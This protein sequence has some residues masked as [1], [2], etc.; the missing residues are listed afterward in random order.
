[1]DVSAIGF[2]ILVKDTKIFPDGFTISRTADG[3]DPFAFSTVTVGSATTDANGYKVYA[4]TPNPT[5]F[6]INLLPTSEEDKNMSLL[7]ESH[8]PRPGIPRTGGEITITVI[9]ADGSSTTANDCSFL[10]GDPKRSIQGDSRYKNKV[11]TFACE[12]YV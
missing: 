6:T 8:R 3:A 4:T 12:D 9:Y 10:T 7:F 11:Y 5:E 2:K 1:M